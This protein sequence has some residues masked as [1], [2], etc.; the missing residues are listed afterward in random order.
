VVQVVIYA[1]IY[2]SLTALAATGQ[3]NLGILILFA[4]LVTITIS[5]NSPLKKLPPFLWTFMTI[6][7]FMGAIYLAGY[8]FLLS[9]LLLF[10]YLI[11]NKISNPMQ[12]RDEMQTLGLCFF[13]CVSS[14]V[15]TD[16]LI[17]AL[18]LT[19]YLFLFTVGM[20]TVTIRAEQEETLR[21][22]SVYMPGLPQPIP[23]R[24][25][26]AFFRLD[27]LSK[28]TA[29]ILL[30][31]LPVGGILFLLI[32]RF[33]T[34]RFLSNL[35]SLHQQAPAMGYSETVDLGSMAGVKK[36]P[37][38]MLR[39][40]PLDQHGK[41]IRVPFLYMRGTSL[42]FYDG[43]R[44]FKSARAT[45]LNDY[46]PPTR[47]ASFTSRP[48]IKASG[49]AQKIFLE[50]D[51][52]PYI[53]SAS[54]PY[55]F[56][57]SQPYEM[58]I[59]NEASSIRLTRGMNEKISYTAYSLMEDGDARKNLSSQTQPPSDD[60]LNSRFYVRLSRLYLQQPRQGLDERISNLAREIT[61]QAKT[62]FEKADRIENFLRANYTYSLDFTEKGTENPIVEFLFDRKTG[63]CEFFATAMAILCRTIGLP[64]RVVNGFYTD[65]WN[66]FGEYFIVRRQDAHSWVE[67]WFDETG[68]L[69]FE[70]TPPAG[71]IR[72]S[73]GTWVPDTIQKIYDTIKFHWY[74]YVIDYNITD[75]MRIGRHLRGLTGG[76][77]RALDNVTLRIRLLLQKGKSTSEMGHIMTWLV[78]IGIVLLIL[79]ALGYIFKHLRQDKKREAQE[80]SSRRYKGAEITWVYEKILACLRE[81]GFE[82]RLSQTPLEFAEVAIRTG[83]APQDFLPLTR[84]YYTLRFRNDPWLPADEEM[85]NDFMR[86][87][88]A[89]AI[90]RKKIP[91]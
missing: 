57:F 87:L 20:L 48:A 66:K 47:I 17:F 54:Y 9:L 1:L 12:P 13:L 52:L 49:L 89:P 84:R 45:N 42:D 77:G 65:E 4:G 18:F 58:I 27:Y 81:R 33:S 51:A 61:K 22:S 79:S 63:H 71:R 68:W 83:S 73:T 40:Q 64:A 39:V 3:V 76:L 5:P 44:W 38:V 24:L 34:Q 6:M 7:S 32:P 21:A 11:L 19:G 82:R 91:V 26:A 70:P 43:K 75:Q 23:P 10:F 46:T 69:S 74:Q 90:P 59:D 41:A 85:F 14:T 60:L 25:D 72:E 16:S 35:G 36:D 88:G 31:L 55:A 53:F 28:F 67:V 56:S 37:K 30:M 8:D 29:L 62:P 80:S 50:P 86:R 15:I 2:W 78:P